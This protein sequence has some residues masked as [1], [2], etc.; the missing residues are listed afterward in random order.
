MPS[1]I[2]VPHRRIIDDQSWSYQ[3]V[4][5][6]K[7]LWN[8]DANMYHTRY[9]GVS[10]CLS[11]IE[12]HQVA[13]YQKPESYTGRSQRW[14]GDQVP[15][16]VCTAGTRCPRRRMT[17]WSR[18]RTCA[19]RR[20]TYRM[21]YDCIDIQVFVGGREQ[22][23]PNNVPFV[24]VALKCNFKVVWTGKKSLGPLWK[25]VDPFNFAVG[26]CISSPAIILT[27]FTFISCVFPTRHLFRI[28]FY[29][30]KTN[31]MTP[32]CNL[33][34]ERSLWLAMHCWTYTLQRVP[35]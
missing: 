28:F 21:A 35:C 34:M 30:L 4:Y 2:S 7:Q 17:Q 22:W 19:L 5:L 29:I 1:K 16:M 9:R 27:K 31:R 25:S 12:I 6:D 33:F 11:L 13:Y 3:L 14:P 8:S 10:D 23:R 15:C 20:D 32:F 26:P 18:G 24:P